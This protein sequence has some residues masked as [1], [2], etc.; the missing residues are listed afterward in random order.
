MSDMTG[1]AQNNWPDYTFWRGFWS[2]MSVGILITLVIIGAWVLTMPEPQ[3]A[4]MLNY[5]FSVKVPTP[6]FNA[7]PLLHSPI[8]VQI[9]VLGAVTA[10]V[11]GALI[12]LL[13]KGTGFH[14][15]LGWS[16]VSSMII[17]AATSIA[18]IAD[19]GNGI[20]ALHAFTALTVISLWSALTGIRRGNVRQHAGSMTGLYV[21]GLIIAGAFAF[22][23]GRVMWQT[24][25][26]S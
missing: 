14:R 10:I 25:F 13:P 20:N 19:F 9:H 16:W 17:V 3:R 24:F 1:S 2:R 22:I 8:S 5:W 6:T 21:G 15:L 4:S 11:V 12:F 26:G 7:I 23:P 18:M